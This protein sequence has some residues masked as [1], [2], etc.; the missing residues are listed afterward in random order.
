MRTIYIDSNIQENID[1]KSQF[2][3]KNLIDPTNLRESASKNH[4]D[5]VIRDPSIKGNTTQVDFNDKSSKNVQFV[6]VNACPRL[7]NLK[8]VNIMLI[9]DSVDES[10]LF[11]KIQ[12]E[13]FNRENV[14]QI[15]TLIL[16][17]QAIHN[18][19]V[20][21]KSN[22]DQ[23]HQESERSRTDVGLSFYSESN[24]LVK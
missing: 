6:K 5:S 2:E 3:I 12:I 19:Q 1:T 13:N 23:F 21:T 14:T 15:N 9:S 8:Q 7:E 11:R 4:V 10:T 16:H 20:I 22:V 18:I 17:T 24:D